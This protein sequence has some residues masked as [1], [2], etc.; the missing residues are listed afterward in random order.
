MLIE[1]FGGHFA[2][3][4]IESRDSGQ[5]VA[6]QGYAQSREG[7]RVRRNPW[8]IW[9]C[10]VNRKSEKEKRKKKTKKKERDF[11]EKL[12]RK[13]EGAVGGGPLT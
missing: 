11:V 13:G 10:R 7:D 2:R 8:R 12:R 1:G 5:Q 4:R 3:K 6:A 9:E